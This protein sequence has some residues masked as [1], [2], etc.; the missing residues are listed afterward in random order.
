MGSRPGKWNCAK[1]AASNRLKL[2]LVQKRFAFVLYLFKPIQFTVF[3]AAI[4]IHCHR[5]CRYFQY[6]CICL[7]LEPKVAMRVQMHFRENLPLGKKS[8]FLEDSRKFFSWL[9]SGVSSRHY[10]M[11]ARPRVSQNES[12]ASPFCRSVSQCLDL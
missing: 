5:L 9:T 8:N 3:V 10:G 4:S 12:F 11:R 2:K 1:D 6:I 7:C